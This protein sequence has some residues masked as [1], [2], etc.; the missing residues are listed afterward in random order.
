M[1]TRKP[2]GIGKK[3]EKYAENRKSEGED[4]NFYNKA[5]HDNSAI[6]ILAIY[7]RQ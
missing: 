2:N 5:M 1:D 7:D 6:E 4:Y 3:Y